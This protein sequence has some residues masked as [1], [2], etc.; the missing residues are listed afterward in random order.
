MF[1]YPMYSELKNLN[2]DLGTGNSGFAGLIG[3]P[4]SGSSDSAI[5]MKTCM[6]ICA[7]IQMMGNLVG[8]VT[9]D[10][11]E[12]PFLIASNVSS[13]KTSRSDSPNTGRHILSAISP[14]YSGGLPEMTTPTLSVP[15]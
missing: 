6:R 9:Q 7:V 2:S 13:W 10:I 1:R 4:D 14:A 15:R 12:P 8:S 3:Q 5:C 11:Q